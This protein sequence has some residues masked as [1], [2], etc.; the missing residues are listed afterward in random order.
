MK[1]NKAYTLA[2]IATILDSTFKGEKDLVVS[3]I[4]E[5]HRVEPGD[6]VFV[7]HPKYYSKALNSLA[8]VVLIN[9][10][11]EFPEGKAI[12]I[13]DDPFKKFN[14]LL[15]YFEPFE[16]PEKL[17]NPNT[18][19]GKGSK[20]HSSVAIGKNVKIGD[21]SLIF[22]N[23]TIGD[24]VTIGSNVIIQPGV[25][26]GSFGFYYKNRPD[27]F[28][29]LLSCGDV[30]IEDNVEIGANCTIDKGVTATTRI[31]KGTKIDNLVQIGHDTIIGEKCLIASGCGISGCVTIGNE[32]TIWGQAGVVSGI[33]IGDK[34]VIQGQSGI[35]KSIEGGKVYLGSPAEESRTKFKEM[36][37]L[38]RLPSIIENLSKNE[39]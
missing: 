22:P 4:N 7:D 13:C 19:I 1:F 38:R 10:D 33:S 31:G 18:S 5:I 32:V 36:A 34:A 6:I 12:I 23:V 14:H 39:R 2:E 28:E 29:R 15:N 37:S 20:I 17:Q 3:G 11:I 21:N 16:F 35:S 26:L 8:T 27:H 30:V 9:S 25:V 24:N